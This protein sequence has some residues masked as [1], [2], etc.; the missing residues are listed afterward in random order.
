MTVIDYFQSHPHSKQRMRELLRLGALLCLGLAPG[1]GTDEALRSS[2]SSAAS[3]TDAAT[4]AHGV[5]DGFAERDGLVEWDV[6]VE[7]SSD[8]ARADS[9]SDAVDN[10]C[11]DVPSIPADAGDPPPECV[12]PCLWSIFRGCLPKGLCGRDNGWRIECVR[13]VSRNDCTVY[14]DGRECYS[15]QAVKPGASA[16]TLVSWFGSG[17]G[18]WT[19]GDGRICCGPFDRMGCDDAGAY[20]VN[21]DDPRCAPWESLW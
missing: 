14:V 10:R 13:G 15:I 17:T 20:R 7:G 2:N 21:H 12:P 11:Y 9:A 4:D 5:Q 19:V 18:G 3:G 8:G 6:L 1:C 16:P